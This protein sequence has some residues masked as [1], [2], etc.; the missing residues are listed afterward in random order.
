MCVFVSLSFKVFVRMCVRM[1]ER[2]VCVRADC[3]CLVFVF[4]HGERLFLLCVCVRTHA[5]VGEGAR[6]LCVRVCCA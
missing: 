6:I 4:L 1:C 5:G 2:C 3:C